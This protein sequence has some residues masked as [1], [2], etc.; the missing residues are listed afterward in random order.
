MTAAE[1]RSFF[2]TM[3][4]H[5]TKWESDLKKIDPAKANA[6]YAV[7]RE[8]VSSRDGALQLLT[9]VRS[10]IA[11]VRIRQR[12]SSELVL[13]ELLANLYAMMDAEIGLEVATGLKTEDDLAV[14]KQQINR[15][16]MKLVDDL[17][18]R[19]ELL[20]KGNCP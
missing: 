17:Q 11:L 14:S 7:G 9:T 15:D 1:Y 20:E 3:E 13:S 12:P 6:S 10:M 16:R 2:D 8:L 18:A 5:S 4:S 19:I